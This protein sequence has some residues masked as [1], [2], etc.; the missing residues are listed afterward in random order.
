MVSSKFTANKLNPKLPPHCKA[1]P[2]P[3]PTRPDFHI[4]LLEGQWNRYP[5]AGSPPDDWLHTPMDLIVPH[6]AYSWERT[7]YPQTCYVKL[8][9]IPHPGTW[10]FIAQTKPVYEPWHSMHGTM[11]SPVPEPDFRELQFFF[12]YS[13][14]GDHADVLIFW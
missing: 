9:W 1:C 10:H 6:R 12:T 8:F 14:E 4:A 5:M 2:P 3:G 13:H 11:S 7:N